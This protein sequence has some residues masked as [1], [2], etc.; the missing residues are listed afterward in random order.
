M[1][2]HAFSFFSGVNLIERKSVS[3]VLCAPSQK[4]WVCDRPHGQ[5]LYRV[6]ASSLTSIGASPQFLGRSIFRLS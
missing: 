4:G 3:A 5:K 6:P 1:Q 2:S